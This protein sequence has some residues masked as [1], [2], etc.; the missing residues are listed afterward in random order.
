MFDEQVGVGPCDPIPNVIG[1]VERAGVVVIG[2]AVEIEK[3][4]GA[5]FWPDCPYGR[6][7]ICISRGTSGDRQR[8]N[9]GQNW[10]T[11]CCTNSGT[12]TPSRQRARLTDSPR[13]S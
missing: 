2:S 11:S 10:G 7:I 5:S 8:F 6:P 9:V 12:L 13:R 1:A 3:H 4:D